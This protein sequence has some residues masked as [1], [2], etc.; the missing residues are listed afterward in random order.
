MKYQT[1]RRV[2]SES[3]T[4]STDKTSVRI[5]LTIEVESVE[6]DVQVCMLRINGRNASE[7]KY[8]KVNEGGVGSKGD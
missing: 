8:V 3:V 7:N 2:V 1:S 6:F 5:N 4:G